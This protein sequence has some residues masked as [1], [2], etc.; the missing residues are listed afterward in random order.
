VRTPRRQRPIPVRT[1]HKYFIPTA[2]LIGRQ[3]KTC[4]APRRTPHCA[5]ASDEV[6]GVTLLCAARPRRPEFRTNF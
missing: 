2:L 6:L 4:Q 1:Y 5:W 3:E